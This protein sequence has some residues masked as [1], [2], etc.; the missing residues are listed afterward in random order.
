MFTVLSAGQQIP[1][2]G[3]S[4][5]YLVVDQWDD[6]F[7]FRT[8]FTLFVFDIRSIRHR[9]GSVKIGQAGLLPAPAGAEILTAAGPQGFQ[10]PSV[11]WMSVSSFHLAKMKTTTQRFKLYPMA[12]V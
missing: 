3:T 10:T 8:M 9:V 7:K 2:H 12:W 5:A 11:S 4:C 6:W 1:Q